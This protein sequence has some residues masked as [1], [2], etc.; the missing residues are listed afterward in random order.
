VDAIQ[1]DSTALDADQVTQRVLELAQKRNT[2][3]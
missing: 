3:N 2:T 1:I